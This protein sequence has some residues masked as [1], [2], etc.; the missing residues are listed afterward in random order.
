M[1]TLLGLTLDELASLGALTL[2]DCEEAMAAFGSTL[3][4]RHDTTQTLTTPD[5]RSN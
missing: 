2:A 3:A 5:R 1:K 4:D